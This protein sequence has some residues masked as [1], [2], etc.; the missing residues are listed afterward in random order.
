MRVTGFAVGLGCTLID[1]AIHSPVF[2]IPA[3]YL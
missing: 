2:Y 3:F 1:N